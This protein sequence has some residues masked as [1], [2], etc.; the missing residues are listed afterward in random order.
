MSELKACMGCG[1][2]ATRIDTAYD[3]EPRAVCYTRDCILYDI[4]FK[5]EAW[6]S[7]PLEDA[8]QAR[9]DEATQIIREAKEINDDQSEYGGGAWVNDDYENDPTDLEARIRKF[10]K[11]AKEAPKEVKHE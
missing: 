6:Q 9:I 5:F 8:L 10:L 7:R 3:G 1:K 2:P 11:G 4:P